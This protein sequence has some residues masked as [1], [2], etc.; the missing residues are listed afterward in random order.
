MSVA[1]S[2]SSRLNTIQ[3]IQAP[4]RYS[5]ITC[6]ACGPSDQNSMTLRKSEEAIQGEVVIKKYDPQKNRISPEIFWGK[7]NF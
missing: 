4:F 7:L 5:S 6:V 3:Y 2:W 1:A